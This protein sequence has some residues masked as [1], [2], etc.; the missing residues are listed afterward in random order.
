M[1]VLI[2]SIKARQIIDS[3]GNPTL[4]AEV[5]LSNGIKGIASVP[6]GASV[7]KSE[8][9]ELRDNNPDYLFSKSVLKAVDNVNGLLS[10]EL[11]GMNPFNQFE[12]DDLIKELDSTPNFSL[13]GANAALGVSMA[14]ADAAG[15]AL[16]IELFQYIG[17]INGFIMPIPMINII[18][19]GVHADNKLDFQEFMIV[20][21]GAPT[22]RRALE[23][24]QEVFHTLKDIL[25][26]K[27]LSTNVGDE[28]G[29]APMLDDNFEALELIIDAIFDSGYTTSEIKLALDVASSEFY[30]DNK[31][32]FENKEL[33]TD[34]MIDY[35]KNLCEKYPIISLEDPLSQD[36]FE[37][38][39]NITSKLNCMLVGDD[40]FTTNP[41]L[42]KRGI[43]NKI[44]NSI[45]IKPNQIGTISDTIKCVEMAKKNCYKTIISHRSAETENTFIADLAVGLNSGFI[46]TGSIS[47]VDRTAKYNRLL[48]I[49]EF[50]AK[51]ALYNRNY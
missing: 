35:L 48:R 20:P 40:L 32:K 51:G 34:K 3:R 8:A 1:T 16:N 9:L 7:G 33:S 23:M 31:Y 38:W 18:N 28:G 45:L 15:K 10:K 39:K 29:F 12:I 4:E 44:A 17:G 2:D 50:L 13:L 25:K 36:D 43:D 26:K 30:Y 22:F 14:V 11:K 41:R 37:G 24:A 47:R 6:S 5:I 21:I 46:K 27:N 42:L 49:E 19:G